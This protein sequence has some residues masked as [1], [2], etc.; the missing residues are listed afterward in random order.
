MRS[1]AYKGL[2]ELLRPLVPFLG[3]SD[4]CSDWAKRE[5]EAVQE[6]DR[7]LAKAG[8]DQQA[9]AAHTLRAELPTLGED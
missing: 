8:M 4:L 5:P 3:T 9:I 6:V 1:S 2:S 7:V